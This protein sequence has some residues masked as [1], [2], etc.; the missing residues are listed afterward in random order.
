MPKDLVKDQTFHLSQVAGEALNRAMFPLAHL[1]KS[2]VK[3]VAI[4]AGLSRI[5]AK[6]ESM[7]ICFIGSRN[8]SNFIDQVINF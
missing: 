8:F 7:G 1:L 6:N 4:D 3:Q 2:E 5:A